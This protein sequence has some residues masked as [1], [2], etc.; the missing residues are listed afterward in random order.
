M[1]ALGGTFVISRT[2]YPFRLVLC[3]IIGTLRTLRERVADKLPVGRC[4]FAVEARS[5]RRSRLW[6]MGAFFEAVRV[7]SRGL[8]NGCV[9]APAPWACDR[10]RQAER[11]FSARLGPNPFVAK[12]LTAS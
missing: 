9:S 11:C 8:I 3:L 2:K 4:S 10:S 7:G 5:A 1:E 12:R 6:R